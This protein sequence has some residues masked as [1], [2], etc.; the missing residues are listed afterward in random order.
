MRFPIIYLLI[1]KRCCTEL[2]S[3]PTFYSCYFKTLLLVL[4]Q[5]WG[6]GIR[7]EPALASNSGSGSIKPPLAHCIDC[8]DFFFFFSVLF[9]CWAFWKIF[10]IFTWRSGIWNSRNLFYF[11]NP[12]FFHSVALRHKPVISERASTCRVFCIP[13]SSE[14]SCLRLQDIC[15]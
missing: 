2:H 8:I 6:S 4:N 12:I 9:Y 1:L 7:P 14:P 11:C 10:L 3:G 13:F 15:F 5:K